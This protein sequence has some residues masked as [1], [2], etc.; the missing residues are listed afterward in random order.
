MSEDAAAAAQKIEQA[1]IFAKAAVAE[2]AIPRCN[3][4]FVT[5]EQ[6]KTELAAFLEIM[7]EQAP[8][9]I[10]GALPGDD[11]YCVLK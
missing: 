10:G 6:M 5:G 11:F 2:K 1:G 8:Q 9:S 3:L 7:F 4:C